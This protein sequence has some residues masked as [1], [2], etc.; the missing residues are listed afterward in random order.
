MTI[1]DWIMILAVFTGPI[2]AVQLTKKKSI[3]SSLES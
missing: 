2:V 3:G 1:S